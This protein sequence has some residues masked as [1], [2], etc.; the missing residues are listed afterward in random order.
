[1]D[2]KL[3]FRFCRQT[4]I[5]LTLLTPWQQLSGRCSLGDRPSSSNLSVVW[6]SSGSRPCRWSLKSNFSQ[7]TQWILMKRC[8]TI[9]QCPY[10]IYVKFQPDRFTFELDADGFWRDYRPWSITLFPLATTGNGFWARRPGLFNSLCYSDIEKHI[11]NLSHIGRWST[12]KNVIR[13]FIYVMN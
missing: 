9:F 12:I 5:L 7:T 1:M 13:F 6:L 11:L 10:T 3:W 2:R 8:K 4:A